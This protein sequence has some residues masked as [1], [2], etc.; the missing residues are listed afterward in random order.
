MTST[1][2]AIAVFVIAVYFV[3]FFR[4]VTRHPDQRAILVAESPQ[5]K[6]G[7]LL[8][9]PVIVALVFAPMPYK[10]I[11]AAMLPTALIG[12]SWLHHRAMARAGADPGFLRRLSA[13]NALGIAGVMLFA[14]DTLQGGS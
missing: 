14:A 2:L 4:L 13:L 12:I 8:L 5:G 7:N 1:L 6:R 9:L 10:A 3:L 11:A